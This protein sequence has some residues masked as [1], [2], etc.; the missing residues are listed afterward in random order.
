MEAFLSSSD[1][2][3]FAEAIEKAYKTN[4]CLYTS[5][6]DALLPVYV[7]MDLGVNDK[8]VIIFFQLAHGEIRIIDYY[9][10]NNKDVPFYCHFMLQDKPYTYHTVFLPHDSKKREITNVANTFE[11]DFRRLFSGTKTVVTVLPRIDKQLSISYSKI[12]LERCVF[13][14]NKVKSLIDKLA[15]YRKKWLES[16]GRYIEEPYHND[17]SN[18]GDAFRYVAQA[19]GHLETISSMGGA[20]DKHRKAVEDRLRKLY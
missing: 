14:V 13:N 4:R 10:D 8:T 2:Y 6:Y 15:K 17:A 1:A 3:Y 7:A 12:S 11:R 5:L 18:Y 19:V 16:V 9:E 20:M